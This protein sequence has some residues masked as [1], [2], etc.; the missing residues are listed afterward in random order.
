[1]KHAT[2]AIALYRA[3]AAI[4]ALSDWMPGIVAEVLRPHAVT[5]NQIAD[6][7]HNHS[8]PAS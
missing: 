7:H 4:E 2:M 5:L 6:W 1:M 8:N 3:A